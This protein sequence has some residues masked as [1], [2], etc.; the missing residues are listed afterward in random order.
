MKL[1]VL[2]FLLL[3]SAVN[4]QVKLKNTRDFFPPKIPTLQQSLLQEV[5]LYLNGEVLKNYYEYYY[6]DDYKRLVTK[7]YDN[8]GILRSQ[9][10]E[11]V[12]PKGMLIIGGFMF[13][14][15]D[16]NI[17]KPIPVKVKK[18]I[19][20]PFIDLVDIY[21]WKAQTR[22]TF[23]NKVIINSTM[24]FIDAS[25]INTGV[26]NTPVIYM[27]RQKT[28]IYKGDYDRNTIQANYIFSFE[29]VNGVSHFYTKK[30]TENVFAGKI[31]SNKIQPKIE[32][33]FM[34]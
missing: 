21:D 4:A 2:L 1:K 25:I 22:A 23:G 20:F 29:P 28:S 18:V 6:E 26:T 12:T 14:Y 11:K 31:I 5:D 30:V 34:F 10:I 16:N 19:T 24:S 33:N 7:T 3:S 32:S 8:Y 9:L 27:Q 17:Q 13:E 15:D